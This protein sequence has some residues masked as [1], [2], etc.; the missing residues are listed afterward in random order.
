MFGPFHIDT[1]IIGEGGG[2]EVYTPPLG[3]GLVAFLL[4]PLLGGQARE[5]VSQL[6]SRL[7]VPS[8]IR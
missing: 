3:I 7:A 8:H 5:E 6:P 1:T 4:E 2:E